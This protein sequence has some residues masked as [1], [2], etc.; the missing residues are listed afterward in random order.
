ME[1]ITDKNIMYRK[2]IAGHF[3]NTTPIFMSLNEWENR[4]NIWHNVP[5]WGI[6]SLKSGDK[7]M[8]LD[9][10]TEE[11]ATYGLNT[12]GLSGYNISPMVDQ[13]LTMRAEVMEDENGLHCRTVI[14]H[15][16]TK[17]RQAFERYEL[18]LTGINAINHL[19]QHLNVNSYED[20][21]ILFAL[22]PNHV[23]ELTALERCFGTIIGR[24]AV[25][26][27]VRDGKSGNYERNS[28]WYCNLQERN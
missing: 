18:V 14:G 1:A 2:L 11:V 27:E 12:F 16:E 4:P 21:Q 5:L 22:H 25:I 6:R 28:G 26:W 17:W 9:I 24:N 20:L 19:K 3:G 15:R 23:V 13:W 10:P 7:R 8:R